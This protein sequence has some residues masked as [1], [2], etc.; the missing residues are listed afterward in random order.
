MNTPSSVDTM[1]MQAQETLHISRKSLLDANYDNSLAQAEEALKL[2]IEA[3]HNESAPALI[4]YYYHYATCLLAKL[5]TSEQLF[6]DHVTNTIEQVS[7]QLVQLNSNPVE[8]AK[9]TEVT[10]EETI[11][12]N[13]EAARVIAEKE[14][15]MEKS[16]CKERFNDLLEWIVVIC[17]KEAELLAYEEDYEGACKELKKIESQWKG[18]LSDVQMTELYYSIGLNLSEQETK[19]EEALLYLEECQKLW[20][21][22]LLGKGLCTKLSDLEKKIGNIGALLSDIHNDI[23]EA[24]ELQKAQQAHEDVFEKKIIQ[25]QVTELGLLSKRPIQA[26]PELN[27]VPTKM[28]PAAN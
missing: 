3:L 8:E 16:E 9:E 15:A 21:T 25:G 2:V 10:D 27:Q 17:C 26:S 19:K 24:D 5:T 7:E 1:L 11:W 28:E 22:K 23:K 4:P 20:Y 13:L 18:S 6:T 12:Q 14:I